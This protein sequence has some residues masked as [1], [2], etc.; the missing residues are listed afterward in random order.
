MAADL[1][2]PWI[3]PAGDGGPG[4]FLRPL[5]QVDPVLLAG[6]HLGVAGEGDAVEARLGD[7]HQPCGEIQGLVVAPPSRSRCHVPPRDKTVKVYA[8]RCIL[9]VPKVLVSTEHHMREISYNLC[10]C[11]VGLTR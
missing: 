1:I 7:G 10:H 11:T 8:E 9:F 4:H 6:V 5:F 2:I 3:G